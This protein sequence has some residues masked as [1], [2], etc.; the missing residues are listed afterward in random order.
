MDYITYESRLLSA[1]SRLGLKKHILGNVFGY[2]LYLLE[3]P[4]VGNN[5]ILFAAGFHGEEPAGVLGVLAFLEEM[6]RNSLSEEVPISFLPLVNPSGFV[7]GC[8]YNLKGESPNSG[9]IHG[10]DEPSVE[11]VIL[12][13]N[14]ELLKSLSGWA[15]VSLHE[16]ADSEKSYAYTFEDKIGTFSTNILRTL[17]C[18]FGLVDD[19]YLTDLPLKNGLIHNFCD[20]SFEDLMFHSGIPRTACTKTPGRLPLDRRVAANSDLIHSIRVHSIISN[21]R[22]GV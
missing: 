4:I 13:K 12:L 14:L 7:D 8:R 18:H 6:N 9:F 19:S 11:G 1:A 5:G 3:S 17:E 20:G 10:D 21:L 2:N 15:F 16:D 22:E